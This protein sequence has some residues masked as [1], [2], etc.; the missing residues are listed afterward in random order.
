MGP[1]SRKTH[2]E[3]K[4]NKSN[5]TRFFFQ[6]KDGNANHEKDEKLFFNSEI[7]YRNNTGLPDELK[8]NIEKLSGIS[9]DDVKVHYNSSNPIKYN[10]LAYTQGTDIYLGHGH[11]DNLPHEAWHV[12]QQRQGKVK[13]RFKVEDKNANDDVSLEI[14]ASKMGNK[15]KSGNVPQ[16]KNIQKKNI[17][18][19]HR[20]SKNGV[21]QRTAIPSSAIILDVNASAET[22]LQKLI[23]TASMTSRQ[24]STVNWRNMFLG[25]INQQ[26]MGRRLGV[27]TH[28]WRDN[29]GLDA[30]WTVTISFDQVDPRRTSRPTERRNITN[31]SGGTSTNNL[32]SNQSNTTGSSI[33]V[34]GGSSSSVGAEVEGISANRGNSSSGT[35]GLNDAYTT[36]SSSTS[37][38]SLTSNMQSASTESINRFI[39]TLRVRIDC[40][41]EAAYSNWDIINPVKWGAHLA[42]RLH[43]SRVYPVGT[44]TYDLPDYNR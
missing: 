24:Y 39:S 10:A 11:E 26:L 17:D 18:Y 3:S 20:L 28:S 8:D 15:A 16:N 33:S 12:V 13:P 19:N 6:D 7:D 29:E 5:D 25:V 43:E 9:L 40:T 23:L 14:E 38:G 44:I 4:N 37:G 1:L 42:G 36:G 31:A 35:I 41:A 30:N 22:I 32:G 2:K 21:I 34:T 27:I